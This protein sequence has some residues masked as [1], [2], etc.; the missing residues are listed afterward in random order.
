MVVQR[1]RPH[2]STFLKTTGE[3]DSREVRIKRGSIGSH[4]GA[5]APHASE[6]SFVGRDA[7]MTAR[8]TQGRS[9]QSSFNTEILPAHVEA[10]MRKPVAMLNNIS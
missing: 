9:Q 1:Q 10:L 8:N 6:A 2:I 7:R 4:D 3:E 5:F